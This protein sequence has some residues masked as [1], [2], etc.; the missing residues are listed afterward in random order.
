MLQEIDEI[1]SF[2]T[3]EQFEEST[4][5]ARKHT[6]S[7]NT[8]DFKLSPRDYSKCLEDG[9]ETL[10][11]SDESLGLLMTNEDDKK[12]NTEMDSQSLQ[13]DGNLFENLHET[14]PQTLR[15]RSYSETDIAKICIDEE[16][17]NNSQDPIADDQVEELHDEELDT[18]RET[19]IRIRT[20]VK[21]CEKSSES[22]S[23]RYKK[24]CSYS[25]KV[26]Y[27]CC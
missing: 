1:K 19:L 10:E 16:E 8:S 21:K 6:D 18:E 22:I 27:C 12:S 3:Q 4:E 14:L 15:R 20:P 11:K 13:F 2:R 9:G 25:P 7:H 24:F 5:E 23:K 26:R 17:T